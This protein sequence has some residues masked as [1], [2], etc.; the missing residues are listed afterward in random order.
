MKWR[1]M[2]HPPRNAFENMAID[3]AMLINGKPTLRFYTWKPSAISIGYFQSIEEEVNLEACR[4]YGVDVVRRITGG[5]AV[6]HDEAGEITYSIVCRASMLPADIM[7]SYRI[8][9]SALA[10]GLK[11]MGL[12]ARHEGINDIVV[13][14]RKISGSAQ[15]RRY[16]NVLQH[17]TI[18]KRVDVDRMFSLL[19]IGREKIRDKVIKDVKERVT[20]IENEIGERSDEEIVRN[21]IKGFEEKMGME[22]E[23]GELN[24]LE[25]EMVEKLREKYGSKEWNFKR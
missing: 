18:L 17:G 19:K 15:T 6:Y 5:G 24:D 16:G 4:R 21:L 11:L 23:E 12:D 22:F 8:I 1:L 2:I 9:C 7:E 14:H 10:H 13:N 20:S 25:W 3:E